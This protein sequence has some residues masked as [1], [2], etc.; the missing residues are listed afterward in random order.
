MALVKKDLT[1]KVIFKQRLEGDE[2]ARPGHLGMNI[3]GRGL[4][5][6]K[7]PEMR[8]SAMFE[9]SQEA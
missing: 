3:P 1:K 9:E 7:R 2:G 8:V 6:Y 4:H 5:K